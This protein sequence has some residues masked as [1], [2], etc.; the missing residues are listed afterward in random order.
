MIDNI[1]NGVYD[2]QV[3]RQS[4]EVCAM[5]SSNKTS[6]LQVSSLFVQKLGILWKQHQQKMENRTTCMNHSQ[7]RVLCLYL[8]HFKTILGASIHSDPWHSLLLN[9]TF[10]IR[11]P[12]TNELLD[13][14]GKLFAEM[15]KSDSQWKDLLFSTFE[16]KSM[17]RSWMS[18]NKTGGGSSGGGHS[19]QSG[20]NNSS[21]SSRNSSNISSSNNIHQFS[22]HEIQLQIVHCKSYLKSFAKSAMLQFL[23]KMYHTMFPLI[24]GQPLN[25]TIKQKLVIYSNLLFEVVVDQRHNLNMAEIMDTNLFK[26]IVH[27]LRSVRSVDI[28]APL[29]RTLVVVVPVLM[30]K[31]R[32]GTEPKLFCQTLFS[33]VKSII[34]DWP[35]IISDESKGSSSEV[36][37]LS[38]DIDQIYSFS[39]PIGRNLHLAMQ[40]F[41]QL[42]YILFPRL[43]LRNVRTQILSQNNQRTTGMSQATLSAIAE[44]LEQYLEHM[45]FNTYL[46][47]SLESCE[48]NM[49]RWK[50]MDIDRW[51]LNFK[52]YGSRGTQQESTLRKA[53]SPDDLESVPRGDDDS[54]SQLEQLF[55]ENRPREFWWQRIMGVQK[56]IETSFTNENTI[57]KERFTSDVTE[58][59]KSVLLLKNELLYEKCL[60]QELQQHCQKL[61]L[62]QVD[63]WKEKAIVDSLNKKIKMQ[64]VEIHRLQEEVKIWKKADREARDRL[65]HWD[66]TLQSNLQS[67]NNTIKKVTEDCLTYSEKVDTLRYQIDELKKELNVKSSR[68]YELETIVSESSSRMEK[69]REQEV[70]LEALMK[71]VHLW[72]RSHSK[73]IATIKQN[74]E[75]NEGIIFR[76]KIIDGISRKLE[77]SQEKLQDASAWIHS[78]T[79]YISSL[80]T[81]LLQSN[82]TIAKWK[83]VL[84]QQ[85]VVHAEN[86]RV[87]QQKYD[88]IKHLNTILQN[89]ITEMRFRQDSLSLSQMD[90]HAATELPV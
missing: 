85:E 62:E 88:T 66:T 51:I 72:E 3:W 17:H 24:S 2:E 74:R 22:I 82:K 11:S 28:L 20:N 47:H 12:M 53:L 57:N 44:T 15:G 25:H 14:Y 39:H 54:Y 52:T 81:E 45:K 35:N 6:S 50:T 30:K 37:Q 19:P 76:N 55:Q 75:L 46:L 86:Q 59:H 56:W 84:Q 49:E 1:V 64:T 9:N 73:L 90:S 79:E 60:R 29:L 80:K 77:L 41:V 10:H 27:I 87:L 65:N 38:S 67:A 13:L 48:L 78:K 89:K 69:A 71:E 63:S 33:V 5:S 40:E 68:I 18:M 36:L 42:N 58:L 4:Q 21:S 23:D 16:Q 7:L 43:F 70:K 83:E 34:V 31:Q 61:R 26:L 8:I 32:L